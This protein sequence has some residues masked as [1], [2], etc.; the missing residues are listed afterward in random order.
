MARGRS[1]PIR[2]GGAGGYVLE[3]EARGIRPEDIEGV[4]HGIRARPFPCTGR[5]EIGHGKRGALGWKR[6]GGA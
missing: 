5:I 6:W 1:S 2:I 4:E 3:R